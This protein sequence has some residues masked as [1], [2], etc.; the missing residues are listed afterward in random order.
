MAITLA[1]C[2][3][4]KIVWHFYGT[5]KRH[6]YIELRTE[7]TNFNCTLYAQSLY[8]VDLCPVIDNTRLLAVGISLVYNIYD[9]LC[10]VLSRH[11][12]IIL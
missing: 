3:N 4:L 11:N 8:W 12:C 5:S 1:T 6:S 10:E 2:Q 7:I 9:C